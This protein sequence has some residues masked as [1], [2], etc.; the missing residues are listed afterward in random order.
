MHAAL[1]TTLAV[2][3]V[4][5]AVVPAP[6]ASQAQT[7]GQ[8]RTAWATSQQAVGSGL[9][10]NTTLRLIARV[11]IGGDA[12]RIRLDNTYGKAPLQVAKA[13]VA[14]RARGAAL[15]AGSS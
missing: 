12:V 10:S 8:W 6:V 2:L 1:R 13:S 7:A 3:F 9:V 15:V 4:L 11:T 14:L 5:A